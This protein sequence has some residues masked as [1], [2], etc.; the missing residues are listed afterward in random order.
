MSNIKQPVSELQSQIDDLKFKFFELEK[1]IQDQFAKVK[2]GKPGPM[3]PY[4]QKGDTGAPGRDAVVTPA[5]L[6][7]IA[8]LVK[9]DAM[10]TV[11]GVLQDVQQEIVH[12]MKQCG[13]MTEDGHAVFVRGFDG[14]DSTVPGPVGPTGATGA[15]GRDGIDGKDADILQVVALAKFDVNDYV[16]QR[17]SDFRSE[18]QEGLR[19]LVVQL[20]QERNVLDFAGNAVPGPA[21]PAGRDG[22]DS[23]V[24]GPQGAPGKEVDTKAL[25]AQLDMRLR[26]S[27]KNDVDAALRGH[28]IELMNHIDN[29][30]RETLEERKSGV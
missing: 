3:G 18:F 7:E 15:N 1:Y 29:R 21:G 19:A 22:K 9:N 11:E 14:K 10:L 2:P 26:R 27:F 24:A 16:T 8:R 17:L 30:I 4:G 13:L 28:L 23:I 25:E 6:K 12:Q 20:L 5:H